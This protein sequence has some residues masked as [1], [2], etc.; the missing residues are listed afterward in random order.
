MTDPLLKNLLQTA[1]QILNR[2]LI[3]VRSFLR[4]LEHKSAVRA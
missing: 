4:E 2:R 3:G 1:K